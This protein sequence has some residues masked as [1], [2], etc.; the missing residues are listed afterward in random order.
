MMSIHV[1]DHHRSEHHWHSSMSDSDSYSDDGDEHDDLQIAGHGAVGDLHHHAMNVDNHD[2]VDDLEDDDEDDDDDDMDKI[3]CSPSIT[4]EDID[5]NFVYAFHN[6]VATV[7]GQANA[8][9]GDTMVLLDD[10]NSYWWLVR[11][12]KD[13]TIGELLPLLC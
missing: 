12:V 4:D 13:N 3:S 2:G 11:V 6:F 10:S 9:K 7:E 1:S 8:A 5:F